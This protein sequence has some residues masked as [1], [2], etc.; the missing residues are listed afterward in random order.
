[1]P[2][3][4]DVVVVGAGPIGSYTAYQ[5]ADRGFKVCLIDSK[6]EIGKDVV[7]AGVISKKAFRQYDLPVHSVLSRISSVTFISPSGQRLEYDPQD[8][9]A[10]VVDRSKFDAELL[11]LARH[12]GARVLLQQSVRNVIAG[13]KYNTVVSR[14]RKIRSKIVVLAT[15]VNYELHKKIGFGKPP[16]FL[17]GSQIELPLS[18]SSSNIEIHMGQKFAPASFGWVI[19]AGA[20]ASRIG[21]IVQRQGK[22]WLKRMLEQRLSFSTAKLKDDALRIKP[23]ACG[24]PRRSVKDNIILVGEAAGQVKTTTGGGIFYGLLCS[25]IAVDKMVKTLKNGVGLNDYDVSWR[26]AL[27]SELDIGVR[28]RKIAQKLSDEDVERLFRFVKK[29]RFWVQLL[30]PRIDF[31]Y[32][33]NFIFFCMKSFE[34]LLPITT[35]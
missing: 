32:H 11:R 34:T 22:S 7:C 35:E 10:Y 3:T 25:E 17:H 16:R 2:K 27:S 9:F 12:V 13:K 23:I 6:K 31:D 14:T 4:Y 30:V 8:I 21:V 26:S 18:F 33:S 28:L 20:Q 19:P 24:A 15:G 29:H 5:L 1:M